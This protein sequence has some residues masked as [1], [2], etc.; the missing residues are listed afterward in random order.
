MG[1][2]PICSYCK[3]FLKPL[4]DASFTFENDGAKVKIFNCKRCKKQVVEVTFKKGLFA[5]LKRFIKATKQRIL[6][7]YPNT[8]IVYKGDEQ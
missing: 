2:Q 4:N 8:E 6:L 7:K 3:S 5:A 1:K